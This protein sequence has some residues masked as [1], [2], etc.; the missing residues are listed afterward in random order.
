M[1]KKKWVSGTLAVCLAASYVLM[2]GSNS[3]AA[4]SADFQWKDHRDRN[5]SVRR[6][7]ECVQRGD[8]RI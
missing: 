8:L 6:Y 3:K 5:L 2:T 7:I 1:L 4:E